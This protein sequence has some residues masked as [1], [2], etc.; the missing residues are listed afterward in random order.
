LSGCTDFLSPTLVKRFHYILQQ[1]YLY[2]IWTTTDTA[3]T[4]RIRGSL[5]PDASAPLSLSIYS[6]ATSV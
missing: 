5:R 2:P 4:N 3:L 1:K 6:S